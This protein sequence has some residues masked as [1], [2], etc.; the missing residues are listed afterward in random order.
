MVRP[1]LRKQSK[2]GTKR[3]AGFR[4]GGERGKSTSGKY[5][6]MHRN[7]PQRCGS[8]DFAESHGRAVN[9]NYH[10][11]SS[12]YIGQGQYTIHSPPSTIIER[13]V[14]GLGS[15]VDQVTELL[16][17]KIV[18]SLHT[19]A[20]L[21]LDHQKPPRIKSHTLLLLRIVAKAQRAVLM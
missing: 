11:L 10:T 13:D 15:S 6:C 5:Y 7:L 8:L 18:F 21:V 1:L 16:L 9:A 12:K 17:E 20:S 4:R 3:H 14:H 2:R 19:Y